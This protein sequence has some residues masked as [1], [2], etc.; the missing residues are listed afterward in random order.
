MKTRQVLLACLLCVA[1]QAI[2]SSDDRF[3]KKYAMMKIYESCFGPE[4]VKQIRKE[5]KEAYAKCSAPPPPPTPSFDEPANSLPSILLGKLPPGFSID[6][7][8]QTITKPTDGAMH[9]QE[10]DLPEHPPQQPQKPGV[11]A[12]RPHGPSFPQQPQPQIPPY[13]MPNPQ[14]RPFSPATPFYQFPY[15]APGLFYPPQY[16]PYQYP[17]QY[18]QG[19]YQQQPYY[20]N[21]RMSRDMDLRDRLDIISR[22]PGAPAAGRVR[23]ITCVMQELGYIDHNLEPNYEQITQ[24]ISNLPVSSE[25][26]GDIQDGLQFCQKFSQCVP[27]VKRDV[28]PLSQELIKPMFF[29]RCYKHKKL[30]A[31]IMKDIRE[32]FTSEDELETDSDFRS[33]SRS[34]RS[35]RED[36]NDPRFEALDEMAVYLYDYLSGGNGFDFDL[37]M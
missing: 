11:L 26:K 24:R 15:S 34:A 6:P 36:L 13:L 31:C 3:I 14:F 10:N 17:Q 22:G 2:A 16:N 29:F 4:V 7:S 8:T 35:I 19:F 12:F 5:M 25:L 21:N 32:R 37:Y 33:L 27:D 30:E 1:A 9:N 23:N 18:P 20:G 28:A